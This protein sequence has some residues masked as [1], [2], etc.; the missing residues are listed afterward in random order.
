M[1]VWPWLVER[2]QIIAN[3]RTSYQDCFGTIYTGI[4]LRFG[5]QAIFRHPVGTAR[6]RN[7][8][9]F[10]QLRKEK[11]AKKMDLGIWLGKTCETDEH[12]MARLMASSLPEPVVEC[13]LTASGSLMQ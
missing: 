13:H 7:H 4:V 5:E 6:G 10:K 2:Y 8:Q 9:T 3:G 12:Y 1:A 11:A